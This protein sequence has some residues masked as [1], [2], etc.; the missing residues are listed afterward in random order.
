MVLQKN[1]NYNKMG[2]F[3]FYLNNIITELSDMN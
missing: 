1:Q 2:G 3:K